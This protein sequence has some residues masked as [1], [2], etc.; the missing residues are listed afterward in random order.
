[1][2][3]EISILTVGDELLIGQ[4]VDTNAAFMARQLNLQ[5]LEVRRQLTV[6]DTLE[7]I[8]AALDVAFRDTSVVL[9]TG[10]LGPT[11]DDVTKKALAAYFGTDMVF[12]EPT[13][14]RI[15]RLFERWGR[16]TTPAHREQCYM[17]ANAMLL[18]N[19]MGTAPGMWIEQEGRILVSMP[20]VPYEM[21]YLL[22]NEVLPRLR[23][24]L[25]VRP[26]IHRTLL[27]VGEGE[28]RLAARIEDIE[29]SLPAHL[30]LA[31]LPN[32]GRVR[33]RI[34]GRGDD[35]G[36]LQQEVDAA[37]AR[38]RERIGEFI[39]GEGEEDLSA[40]IGERLRAQSLTLGTAESCTGGYLA[41]LI[42]AIPGSSDY[43]QG[44]VVSYSNEIK[45]KLLHVNPDTLQRHGAVSEETVRE[46]VY[47]ARL[48]LN[49]DV[50][51]AIS[52]IAGPGG[53]TPGKPVGTIWLAVGNRDRTEAYLLRAGKDR[54]KNIQ[55]AAMHALGRLWRFLGEEE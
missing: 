53:G 31:Y 38:I 55:Y 21:E 33:I 23:Q 15:Q 11:R 42:T 4:V 40:K 43:F 34:T 35:A 28:S 24:S 51:V 46:M 47:G 14:E 45:E 26:I 36:Q 18:P 22:M 13:W 17:P 9:M 32:L 50:A 16:S 12:D 44:S 48:A 2:K 30:K 41:H 39:Y 25:S 1:M 52:G 54:E 20:G 37:A 49:V 19:K 27:T 29:D 7:A 3:N 5:G 10:G 8:P 6:A